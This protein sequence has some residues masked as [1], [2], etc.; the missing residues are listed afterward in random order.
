M[1]LTMHRFGP[2]TGLP[3][4]L[5]HGFPLDFRMWEAVIAELPGVPVIAVNA[6]GFGGSGI[7]E[8]EPSLDAYA[9]LLAAGLAEESVTR[10][11]VVGLSMGGYAAMALAESHPDL[12]AGIGLLDTKAGADPEEAKQNR[13][14][15]A[16]AAEGEDGADAVAPMVNAVLG[17][18]THAERP[19]VVEVLRAWLAEA[20]P[21]GIA[22]GQRAMAARPDRHAVL[23]KLDV[24]ALVLRGDEDDMSPAE[25][26]QRM[27]DALGKDAELITVPRA[28]HMSAIETPYAVAVAIR[29]LHEHV[30]SD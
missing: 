10:A 29:R 18:T 15:I 4:V 2:A 23:E 14:A 25:D 21:A 1:T 12:V 30:D 6:P 13:L 8:G 17:A 5:L 28:G 3:V 19:E 9:E 27:A 24:P 22:W 26:A 16:D 7:P 20:P 11:V